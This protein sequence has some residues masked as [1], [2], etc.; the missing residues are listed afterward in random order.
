MK[1]NLLGLFLTLS[2]LLPSVTFAQKTAVTITPAERKIAEAITAAQLKDYLYYVA[3]D[4]MEGR[5]TPSKGLDLTAKFIGTMLSRWGFKPAGDDGTFFQKIAL[6]RESVD[7][8][9]MKL[10]VDGTTYTFNDDY[11]RL[12]GNA[13]SVSAP[14]VFGKDGWMVKSKNI[15]ALSG[16][17][18][19]GKIVVLAGSGFS[20]QYI[21]APPAGV[22]P[23]DLPAATA[24][25]DWADPIRNATDKGAAG[26]IV[27]APQQL[28][29]F[30]DQVK[31]FFSRGNMSPEKLRGDRPNQ[32]PTPVML[33]GT[34]IRDAIF[35][36][37]SNPADKAAGDLGKAGVVSA[38]SKSETLWTQ[39][40][41]ALWEGADPV[42][43]SEMVAIGAHYDHVGVNPNARGDDKIFN[44]ADDDGSGTVAVL[45]IAE[46]LAKAP[47]RPKRSVLLVWHAGEEK[48]LWGS[49]YFN[50]FPTVDIKKVTA[51]LNIDMIGR[52]K[53]PGYMAPCDTNPAPGRKPCNAE[54]SGESEIYVIGSEMMS[55]TLGAVTKGTNDGFLKLN[56]NYRYDDPKDPNRFFFR[57]DHFNYAVNGI[58]VVF[59]FDGEHE[60]YHGAG[61]HPDKIDYAKME[62]V[63]R[64][65][66][67]TLWELTDLKERPKVD[68]QLPPELTQR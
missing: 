61:D 44:G 57:S 37:G 16:V 26:V 68:K 63:T 46:A 22:T 20:Q 43:K 60:D 21:V 67:L 33:A 49:E 59:W 40:V 48:G 62:K 5:D 2:L 65:I 29:G 35:G 8:A 55:S 18:V 58:P 11:F 17:D 52:S 51:Q 14:L 24:G 66:F 45:S 28:L 53:K 15:D 23:A 10:S 50:K 7:A 12:A 19:K 31:G 6:K 4:E 9:S 47:K 64:T 36:A 38:K 32:S 56:Y 27:I 30:W 54:L 25:T 42:L 3:S 1:K 34:K 13:D 41:V 39:N